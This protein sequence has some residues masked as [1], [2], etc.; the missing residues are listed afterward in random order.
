MKAELKKAVRISTGGGFLASLCCV[1]PLIIVLFGIGG[2]S[3]ALGIVKYRPYFIFVG[4]LFIL[5]SLFFY[6]KK[7][8]GICNVKTI[9]Q[10]LSLI[11]V[12]LIA[13]VIIWYI[14]VY[15]VVPL[16]APYIYS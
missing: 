12:T 2:V 4:A 6:I 16:V 3:T 11:I 5:A 10:N 13:T 14:L 1:G 15:I 8:H 7:R 9:K